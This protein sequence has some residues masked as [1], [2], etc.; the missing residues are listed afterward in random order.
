MDQIL[1]TMITLTTYG[2]WLRGDQ[3]GWVENGKT[4]PPDPE[5]ETADR[6]R[7]QHK[8]FLFAE[9]Q[10]LSVGR[11]IGDSLRQ[12]KNVALLALTV[13]SWHCH[14]VM[15]PTDHPIPDIVKCAKDAA[16][17]GLCVGRPIWTDGYDK[18]FCF[19]RA[20]VRNRIDYV[21]RHNLELGLPA[22]PWDFIVP[23]ARAQPL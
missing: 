18:R 15:G 9:S 21:E 6:H 20:A 10:F 3:R 2:T 14:V 13:Q 12:R 22:K 17:Y 8:P 16:R 4:L 23:F 7:S 1:A 5:L 19:D 11:C